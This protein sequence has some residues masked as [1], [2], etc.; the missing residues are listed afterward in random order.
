MELWHADGSMYV[1]DL[2]VILNK[3]C[4][5]YIPDSPSVYMQY[6]NLQLG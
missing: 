4:D 2:R 5:K 3:L 6:S 1:A